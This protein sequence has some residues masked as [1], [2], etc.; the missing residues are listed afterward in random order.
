M[1]TPLKSMLPDYR[2]A[3]KRC[4]AVIYDRW[5]GGPLSPPDCMALKQVDLQLL[6]AEARELVADKGDGWP[7]V[8]GVRDVDVPVVGMEPRLAEERWMSEW[9]LAGGET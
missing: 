2:V 4:Q 9:R 8:V 1:S 3:E 6:K 7:V 5:F